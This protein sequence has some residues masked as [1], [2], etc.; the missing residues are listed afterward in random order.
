[1]T[2]KSSRSNIQQNKEEATVFNQIPEGNLPKYDANGNL[3]NSGINTDISDLFL[4]SKGNNYIFVSDVGDPILNGNS[5]LEAEAYVR[6][7]TP[8]GLPLSRENRVT[9]YILTGTY[10]LGSD[11]IKLDHLVDIIGIGDKKDIV[12]KSS[13]AVGTFSVGTVNEYTIKN[14][15]II[16]TNTGKSI[17]NLDSTETALGVI[18]SKSS[19]VA[20]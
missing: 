2:F 8:N 7:L 12:I 16:N 9:I 10:D 15:T 5:L 1:M 4:L 13:N 14:C 20:L 19:L 17:S 3:I 11:N 6:T 18:Y